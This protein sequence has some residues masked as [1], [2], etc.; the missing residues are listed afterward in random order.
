MSNFMENEVKSTL[1]IFKNHTK[2]CVQ[3]YL[4]FQLK[5]I[6]NQMI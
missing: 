4:T 1:N 6:K 2:I 5:T 3:M